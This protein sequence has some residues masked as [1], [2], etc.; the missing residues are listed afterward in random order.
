MS[1]NMMLILIVVGIVVLAFGIRYILRK[2][3]Y[4]GV[5]AISNSIKDKKNKTDPPRQEN[6]ADRFK[7]GNP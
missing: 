7:D 5:D 6:L 2:L 4:K 3:A 1:D